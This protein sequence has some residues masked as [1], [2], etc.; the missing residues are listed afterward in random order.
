MV[1][2]Q[3]RHRR[4]SG[5]CRSQQ[6]AGRVRARARRHPD[7]PTAA[8]R[9]RRPRGRDHP[10]DVRW[11][12]IDG[13]TAG[14]TAARWQGR[15]RTANRVQRGSLPSPYRLTPYALPSC[16]LASPCGSRGQ[17]RSYLERHEISSR[18]LR[19]TSPRGE[20]PHM[21]SFQQAWR[22]P[23]TG[24]LNAGTD[25]RRAGMAGGL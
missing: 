5:L 14:R 13:K 18:N 22:D 1:R 19:F 3:H 15:E 8:P 24:L 20:G 23:G 17:E 6:L 2:D 11:A 21:G 10:A 25:P 12:T 9:A 16:R 7:H 4:R